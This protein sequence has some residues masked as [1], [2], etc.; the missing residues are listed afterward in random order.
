M[1]FYSCIFL[2]VLS[3]P[4]WFFRCPSSVSVA[5]S[6][7]KMSVK[8]GCFA[9]QH[10]DRFTLL[11]QWHSTT[12]SH[13]NQQP[14]LKRRSPHTNE[15]N[16][17][18]FEK[19]VRSF[20]INSFASIIPSPLSNSSAT[21]S[22]SRRVVGNSEVVRAEVLFEYTSDNYVDKTFFVFKIYWCPLQTKSKKRMQV[23]NAKK[24]TWSNDS[25]DECSS[26]NSTGAA[27]VYSTKQIRYSSFS[28][29]SPFQIAFSPLFKS[30]WLQP[31]NLKTYFLMPIYVK[32]GAHILQ[33]CIIKTGEL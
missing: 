11:I 27:F 31:F 6:E 28:R 1:D 4:L 21:F 33:F 10:E 3:P 23:I 16:Q 22:I 15:I 8:N 24:L 17:H 30:E 9:F 29:I 26:W 25:I 32:T 5:S 13:C 19:S 18:T 14:I 7:M 12:R 2:S 20:A